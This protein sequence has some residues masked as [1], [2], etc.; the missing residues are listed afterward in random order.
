MI[1]S[2]SMTKKSAIERIEEYAQV[3]IPSHDQQHF[4]E[5]VDNELMGLHSGNIIRFKIKPEEYEKWKKH[6]DER[7]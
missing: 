3:K 1:V 6:W 7:P 2:K 4:I 5:V